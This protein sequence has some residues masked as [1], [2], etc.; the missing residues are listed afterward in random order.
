MYDTSPTITKA[1]EPPKIALLL[2]LPTNEQHIR[3]TAPITINIKPRFFNKPF[4][5]VYFNSYFFSWS[6]IKA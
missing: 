5:C 2:T 1:I 6:Q 3:M 4:M